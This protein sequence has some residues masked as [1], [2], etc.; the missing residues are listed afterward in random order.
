M[1]AWKLQ[2]AKAKFSEVVKEA[3]TNGPQAITLKGQRA[4]VVLSKEA[5]DKL[6]KPTPSFVEFMRHSPLAKIQ[7]NIERSASLTRDIDL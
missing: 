5:Y 7:I 1:R 3:T 6:V 4:V 2:D